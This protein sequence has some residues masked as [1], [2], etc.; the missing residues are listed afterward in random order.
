IYH[1]SFDRFLAAC[2]FAHNGK[3]ASKLIACLKYS[4]KLEGVIESDIVAEGTPALS[5]DERRRF[6]GE[7]ARIKQE[8]AGSTDPIWISRSGAGDRGSRA[9][10]GAPLAQTSFT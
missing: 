2:R 8:L 5:D 1:S 6:D 7:Y 10:Q 3:P 9:G 4:L